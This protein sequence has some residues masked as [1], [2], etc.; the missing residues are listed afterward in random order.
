MR[1]GP[2]MVGLRLGVGGWGLGVGALGG[3]GFCS[4]Q[5]EWMTSSDSAEESASSLSK[6]RI[7]WCWNNWRKGKRGS[8]SVWKVHERSERFIQRGY[9]SHHH[10][11][12]ILLYPT[13][14][15]RAEVTDKEL[16]HFLTSL[17]PLP[18][19][20]FL[21]LQFFPVIL[22]VMYD[23]YMCLCCRSCWRKT[24]YSGERHFLS[25]GMFSHSVPSIIV[26]FLTFFCTSSFGIPLLVMYSI[27]DQKNMGAE[28]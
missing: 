25:R 17:L 23:L 19:V 3:G 6:N 22:P 18:P 9:V 21:Q 8:A 2:S 4:L 12:S 5:K 24:K 16:N 28:T 10:F 27:L 15:V 13:L 26:A 20:H 14:S 7:G 11:L 1:R